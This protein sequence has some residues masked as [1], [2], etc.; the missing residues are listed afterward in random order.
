MSLEVPCISAIQFSAQ[1]QQRECPPLG[2][3]DGLSGRRDANKDS[4]IKSLGTT[5]PLG[6]HLQASSLE[7]PKM[8]EDGRGCR[9]SASRHPTTFQK[10]S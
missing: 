6:V 7:L 3:L 10:R 9:S 8:F 5:H 4:G 2:G 1:L